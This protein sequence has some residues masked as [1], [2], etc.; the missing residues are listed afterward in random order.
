MKRLKRGRGGIEG[1]KCL[2]CWCFE[3]AMS[4]YGE[5]NRNYEGSDA[6]SDGVKNITTQNFF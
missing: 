4:N 3:E 2:N 6:K 1:H 5:C